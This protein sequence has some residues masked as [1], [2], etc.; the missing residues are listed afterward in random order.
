MGV[1]LSSNRQGRLDT[2]SHDADE[3]HHRSSSSRPRTRPPNIMESALNACGGWIKST[4]KHTQQ[5]QQ[6]QQQQ[7]VQ[8]QQQQQQ[9]QQ[10]NSPPTP[11]IDTATDHLKAGTSC[12]QDR[13]EVGGDDGDDK[14]VLVSAA[15]PVFMQDSLADKDIRTSALETQVCIPLES[16]EKEGSSWLPSDVDKGNSFLNFD[17]ENFH[18]LMIPCF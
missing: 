5:H 3:L 13:G 16:L 6:H 15:P 4:S 1:F 18:Q 12:G 7:Q 9:Q 10:C 14:R 17:D 2:R 8:Q 11:N